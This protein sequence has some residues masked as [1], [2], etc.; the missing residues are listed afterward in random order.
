MRTTSWRRARK[1]DM[2]KSQETFFLQQRNLV[3]G[4]LFVFRLSEVMEQK[5][6]TEKAAS[7]NQRQTML[8]EVSPSCY[9]S[10][11]YS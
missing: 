11:T 9:S 8:Q 5:S 3:T 4:V 1:K 10:F 6:L 7:T 2:G